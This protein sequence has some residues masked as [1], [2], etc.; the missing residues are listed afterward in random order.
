MPAIPG[1]GEQ[2]AGYA[3]H[4][5]GGRG[6]QVGVI[7]GD[8]LT[9][10][11]SWPNGVSH[12]GDAKVVAVLAASLLALALTIVA[13]RVGRTGLAGPGSDPQNRQQKPGKHL[14]ER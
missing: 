2:A 12:C 6:R 14:E 8:L 7:A 10:Y 9:T 13:I 3:R 11:I 4:S 1:P 5:P